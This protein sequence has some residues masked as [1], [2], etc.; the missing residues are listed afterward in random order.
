MFWGPLS[1]V[2][3]YLLVLVIVAEFI[4]R[5]RDKDTEIT[6]K[7]VHIG[8]GNV[9][10]FAW[11]LQLPAWIGVGAAIVAAF[12]A[13]IAY[14]VPILPSINSVGR[15][16][17]GTFFYAVSIGVLIAW[18]WSINRPEYA[19]LGILIM[20]W[21]DGLAAIVGQNFGTHP[22]QIGEMT[23]SFEGSLTMFLV[24]FV[25]SNLVLGV[26]LWGEITGTILLISLIIAISATLL[27]AF[28]Q[29][30]IDNLTVPL[31]SAFLGF[32]LVGALR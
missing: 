24:S 26:L 2:L 1:F 10:L 29:W 28:S 30:G 8:A 15:K 12:I 20:T 21:G 17:L 25:I 18:F 32:F 23:K 4:A 13:I 9:I 16:S 14:F 7:I 11:W 3:V 22:Y 6:R 5:F 27:E 31:G 19:V